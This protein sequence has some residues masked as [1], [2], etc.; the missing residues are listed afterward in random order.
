VRGEVI[1][2]QLRDP[3]SAL[4]DLAAAED[5]VP[6]WLRS[7]AKEARAMCEEEA[8]ASRKRKRSVD[9]APSYTGHGPEPAGEED[10]ASPPPLWRAVHQILIEG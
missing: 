3:K 10:L 7:E 8:Q 5:A 2:R 4:E 9:R 6:Q 1:R